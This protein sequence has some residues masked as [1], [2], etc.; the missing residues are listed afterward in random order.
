MTKR[1]N[2]NE[3]LVI[4]YDGNCPLC[5]LEMQKLKQHDANNQIELVNLHQTN[6]NALYP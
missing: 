3:T 2:I 6:F 4:F 5:G 1:N